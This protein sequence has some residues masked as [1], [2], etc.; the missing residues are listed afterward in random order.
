[1]LIF[2]I[3]SP[4]GAVFGAILQEFL[5]NN[6][7]DI[8]LGKGLLSSTTVWTPVREPTPSSTNAYV[9]Y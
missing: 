4:I 5:K 6:R 1:M 7:T 3:S 2:T 8:I 9:G